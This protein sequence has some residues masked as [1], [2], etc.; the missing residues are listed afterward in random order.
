MHS[1][2]RN[3]W[4]LWKF[5]TYQ[6]LFFIIIPI[7]SFR[8]IKLHL[9]L[10]WLTVF[11]CAAE[12]DLSILR[13]LVLYIVDCIWQCCT[14]HSSPPVEVAPW[15]RSSQ[16]SVYPRT[17][18]SGELGTAPGFGQLLLQRGPDNQVTANSRDLTRIRSSWVLE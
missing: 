7:K 16:S 14:T 13:C 2:I 9:L 1:Y 12:W 4:L 17:W 5:F 8:M 6:T 3:I 18:R 11:W 15:Q 10:E